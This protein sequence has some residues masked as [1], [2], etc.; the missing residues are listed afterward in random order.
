MENL[1]RAASAA[2]AVLIL[3]ACASTWQSG[4]AVQPQSYAV[5]GD[6]VRRYAG[7]L[8]R[9]VV[10]EAMVE[11]LGETCARRYPGEIAGWVDEETR[12][13]LI[14]WK[15]CVVLGGRDAALV[16]ALG[17]WQARSPEVRRPGEALAA[18]VRSHAAAQAADGVLALHAAPQ[19]LDMVDAM[20]N[21]FV[22]GMPN[23]SKAF[24]RDFSAG[25]YGADG[26]LVW[27][28]YGHLG[29]FYETKESPPRQEVA[30]SVESLLGPLENAIPEILL[31]QPSIQSTP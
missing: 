29:A 11:P 5:A 1:R 9:L 28:R 2:L 17:P 21:V 27:Q 20:L 24:S 14:D 8:R 6:N 7:K 25:L 15:G 23:Y 18:Q 3:G 12:A 10:L 13:Y 19:C 22:V 26:A 31:R 30:R 4:E 16:R